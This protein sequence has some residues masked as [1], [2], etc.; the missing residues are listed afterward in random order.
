M[1]VTGAP[2]WSVAKSVRILGRAFL[3]PGVAVPSDVVAGV[4]TGRT[5]S[6]PARLTDMPVLTS[7]WSVFDERGAWLYD[8]MMSAYFEPLEIG[9]DHV[10]RRLRDGT[11]R[12]A[13]IFAVITPQQRGRALRVRT[14][15]ARNAPMIPASR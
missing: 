8:V 4:R 10:S 3:L 15:Q 13:A 1:G 14:G 9:R 2:R 7:A 12:L 6:P 5:P 11:Q